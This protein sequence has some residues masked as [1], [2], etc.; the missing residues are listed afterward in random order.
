MAEPSLT[1]ARTAERLLSGIVARQS[2]EPKVSAVLHTRPDD[3]G[4]VVGTHGRTAR[5]DRQRPH[6]AEAPSVYP[7]P[8]SPGGRGNR[9]PRSAGIAPSGRL[10]DQVLHK[11]V[12]AGSAAPDQEV[13]HKAVLDSCREDDP[14]QSVAL[15]D[16]GRPRSAGLE[17]LGVPAPHRAR[18]QLR[19]LDGSEGGEDV[20]PQFA[21]VELARSRGGGPVARRAISRRMW[22]AGPA[23]PPDRSTRPDPGRN[24]SPRGRRRLRGGSGVRTLGGHDQDHHRVAG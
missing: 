20:K 21:L 14:E 19:H 8:P 6:R 7:S 16:G 15:G 4:P 17:E 2:C 12:D 9:R 5:D 3:D 23:P 13:Q 18:G 1:T 11:C 10:P 22:P 24:G